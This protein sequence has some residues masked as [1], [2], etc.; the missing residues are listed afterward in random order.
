MGRATVDSHLS[1]YNTEVLN[2]KLTNLEG[3]EPTKCQLKGN[4]SWRHKYRISVEEGELKVERRVLHFHRKTTTSQSACSKSTRSKLINS[5]LSSTQFSDDLLFNMIEA[6]KIHPDR[7]RILAKHISTEKVIALSTRAANSQARQASNGVQEFLR[8]VDM[9][10]LDLNAIASPDNLVVIL[11]QCCST[12][13]APNTLNVEKITP[14]IRSI[15]LQRT[16]ALCEHCRSSANCQFIEPFLKKIDLKTL[17]IDSLGD[18]IQIELL[19]TSCCEESESIGM[20]LEEI[21]IKKLKSFCEPNEPNSVWFRLSTLSAE[22]A[23]GLSTT[24]LSKLS[25]IHPQFN[26]E[27]FDRWTQP[28]S[29][30]NKTKLLIN[31]STDDAVIA[32]SRAP[33]NEFQSII[34]ELTDMVSNASDSANLTETE[35]R[36]TEIL[37]KISN[38]ISKKEIIIDRDEDVSNE[39]ISKTIT[40]LNTVGNIDCIFT[41]KKPLINCYFIA[42]IFY[43][44]KAPINEQLQ[45]KIETQIKSLPLSNFLVLIELFSEHVIKEFLNDNNMPATLILF[46][47]ESWAACFQSALCKQQIDRRPDTQV[48]HFRLFL[49]LG[50]EV[51]MWLNY[52]EEDIK[53][54]ADLAINS[55]QTTVRFMS[56]LPPRFYKYIMLFITPAKLE[57]FD[58]DFNCIPTETWNHWLEKDFENAKQYLFRLNAK[59]LE[60]IEQTYV[61]FNQQKNNKVRAVSLADIAYGIDDE[62]L[63]RLTKE[64]LTEII[65]IFNSL[66]AN[67]LKDKL[68]ALSEENLLKVLNKLNLTLV[69]DFISIAAP[70]QTLT[71]LRELTRAKQL[72]FNQLSDDVWR[73]LLKANFR[74]AKSYL[75]FLTKERLQT[76]KKNNEILEIKRDGVIDYFQLALYL[77][78]RNIANP[79]FQEFNEVIN[80]LNS[81]PA[82]IAYERLSILTDENFCKVLKKL[83]VAL[84]TGILSASSAPKK[85]TILRQLP[86]VIEKIDFNRITGKAWA[87]WLDKDFE[88]AK[89]YLKYLS[90]ENLEK[91][92]KNNAIVEV[93]QNGTPR[94]IQ[95][96]KHFDHN[97]LYGLGDDDLARVVQVIKNLPAKTISEFLLC[98]GDDDSCWILT[99]LHPFCAVDAILHCVDVPTQLIARLVTLYSEPLDGSNKLLSKYLVKQQI[100][101][102]FSRL[103]TFDRAELPGEDYSSQW[104]KKDLNHKVKHALVQM[105]EGVRIKIV[106]EAKHPISTIFA[107]I[108]LNHDLIPNPLPRAHALI[109]SLESKSDIELSVFANHLNTKILV[110]WMGGKRKDLPIVRVRS[111]THELAFERIRAVGLAGSKKSSKRSKNIHAARMIFEDLVDYFTNPSIPVSHK[112]ETFMFLSSELNAKLRVTHQTKPPDD[113]FISKVCIQLHENLPDPE[114][115]LRDFLGAI[116]SRCGGALAKVITTSDPKVKAEDLELINSDAWSSWLEVDFNKAY[117]YF[118][119][120]PHET[121]QKLIYHIKL[122]E[123]LIIAKNFNQGDLLDWVNGTSIEQLAYWIEQYDECHIGEAIDLLLNHNKLHFISRL[124]KK[125]INEAVRFV[126]NHISRDL[127]QSDESV[128]VETLKSILIENYLS[129]DIA[130]VLVKLY[131][132]KSKVFMEVLT[133][134]VK[135]TPVRIQALEQALKEKDHNAVLKLIGAFSAHHAT[136]KEHSSAV[137][138]QKAF[139]VQSQRI[140]NYA[141]KIDETRFER[142]Q[143]LESDHIRF[144]FDLDKVFPPVYQP[145]QSW[146]HATIPSGSFKFPVS[147]DHKMIEFSA[148]ERRAETSGAVPVSSETNARNKK[149]FT[150]MK[151]I[152]I[153]DGRP[154]NNP[155][156]GSTIQPGLQGVVVG[157]Q[158]LISVRSGEALDT[159]LIKKCPNGELQHPE[160]FHQLLVDMELMHENQIFFRDIK[161][162]NLLYVDHEKRMDGTIFKLPKPKLMFIDLGD[163]CFSPDSTSTET[164]IG[165]LNLFCGTPSK[166]TWELFEQRQKGDKIAAKSADEYAVLYTFLRSI[167]LTLSKLPQAPCEVRN[168]QDFMG[169]NAGRLH[170]C[171]MKESYVFRKGILHHT[172]LKPA[173]RQ[174]FIDECE[175]FIKDDYQGEVIRFLEDPINNPFQHKLSEMLIMSD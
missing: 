46:S 14:L 172:S 99:Q 153:S 39:L 104:F 128:S 169:V 107:A 119:M 127:S 69:K 145:K 116:P 27:N 155:F 13:G 92:K 21:G 40:F 16:L 165:N 51:N 115:N 111:K 64:Q 18:P 10:R 30:A 55:E 84:I 85:S 22:D 159:H 2:Q 11:E 76:V 166:A 96:A 133:K 45:S 163:M 73:A 33:D 80:L 112:A 50:R 136:E 134:V 19:I 23:L 171:G 175:P 147:S 156:Q 88:G 137:T 154:E 83:N 121:K 143:V 29:V 93:M 100:P 168:H 123:W 122:D 173:Q 161:E 43:S 98:F 36:I 63:A 164:P 130:E 48:N 82:D 6:K 91:V 94:L 42:I 87:E 138:V 1:D 158:K 117:E 24:Q 60:S 61:S 148:T 170:A 44:S 135:D 77:N 66:P 89:Q 57:D 144:F 151:S 139:R 132:Q 113:L 5:T 95:V 109:K 150:K 105:S 47:S 160:C 97:L 162:S 20:A 106:K 146:R 141:A 79:T 124:P 110:D 125:K 174:T 86:D 28:T 131:Q 120:L 7:L 49:L 74:E 90:E 54:Y 108:L 38:V 59:K 140:K 8:T 81:L 58:F 31:L 67:I 62:K 157:E 32:L 103:A 118:K 78:N 68:W 4:H 142:I 65:I 25:L 167:S 3:N 41:Q 52:S 102:F 101:E 129:L 37:K 35:K 75:K 26:L 34:F 71:I 149:I 126:I 114:Q 70:R 56:A 9:E 17:Q 53:I 152:L 72:D 15:N 12:E